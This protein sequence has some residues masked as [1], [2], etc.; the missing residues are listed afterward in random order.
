M[1]TQQ[2]KISIVIPVKNGAHWL[3]DCLRGIMNQTLAAETEIIAIDSGSTD[4]SIAILKKH[5][6]RLHCIR[7]EDFNHGLTRMYGAEVSQGE[8]VVMTVQDA[9]AADTKWLENLLDGFS[10]GE[11]VA[12]VCGSQIV[13]HHPD[14]NPVDWYRPYG[15]EQK[16]V[17]R[18][19]PA[20]VFDALSPAEKK[21][22]CGW[23]DVTAMYRR[24]VLLRL[25]FQAT[26][27]SEDIIWAKDALRSGYALV[28]N[29][30]AKVCHYHHADREF[31]F[32]RT[33]TVMHTRYKQF[34]F[35]H[36]RP[37]LSFRKLLSIIKTIAKSEPLTLKQK[38]D[39][40]CY[41]RE[42]L[43]GEQKAF[44]VFAAALAQSEERLD[45]VHERYCGRPQMHQSPKTKEPQTA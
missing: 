11:N 24:A 3:E 39:W 43:K 21:S 5:R 7:P 8:Y 1:S 37:Q 32:R 45:E 12:A 29:P 27:C 10:A 22:A 17:Y 4:D 28:Y 19:G 35:I 2:P 6:V 34:R 26:S 38:W 14:K 25:P 16:K 44:D 15:K 30:A 33:L 36:G 9:V 31:A 42:Q 13:P 41:N 23:D 20:T 18:F 40:F